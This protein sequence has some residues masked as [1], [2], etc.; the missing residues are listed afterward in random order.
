ML[1]KREGITKKTEEM[2]LVIE[3]HIVKRDGSNLKI[4]D[5]GYTHISNAME[6]ESLEKA[7]LAKK[8][9]EEIAEMKEDSK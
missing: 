6:K 3:P 8:Q 5:L 2:V 9:Q 1:F 7:E 4:E